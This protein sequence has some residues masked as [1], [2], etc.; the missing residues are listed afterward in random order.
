[1]GSEYCVVLGKFEIVGDRLRLRDVLFGGLAP[2]AQAAEELARD[3][4]MARM[5]DGI[6]VIPRVYEVKDRKQVRE[7][8][9]AARAV[10]EQFEALCRDA[11]RAERQSESK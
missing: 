3:G 9:L 8:L 1:M 11:A 2:D 6:T 7:I 4:V 5:T 10:Y